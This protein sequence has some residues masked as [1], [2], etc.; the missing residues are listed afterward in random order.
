[1]DKNKIK[2]N[3]II[4]NME[5]REIVD[6]I[7]VFTTVIKECGFEQHTEKVE[8]VMFLLDCLGKKRS[9]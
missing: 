9:E 4:E 6:L 8:E 7:T 2:M 1:M 5:D 3:A